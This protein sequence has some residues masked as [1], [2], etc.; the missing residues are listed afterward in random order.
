MKRVLG[1]RC[2]PFREHWCTSCFYW[3]QRPLLLSDTWYLC[4]D[5]IWKSPPVSFSHGLKHQLP[6]HLKAPCFHWAVCTKGKSIFWLKGLALRQML[7]GTLE[8]KEGDAGKVMLLG[9]SITT[10]QR[11]FFL[12]NKSGRLF[13]SGTEQ[14]SEYTGYAETY[15][16]ARSHEDRSERWVHFYFGITWPKAKECGLDPGTFCLPST[17]TWEI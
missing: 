11:H 4:M 17:L 7:P 8:D 6:S 3:R 16:W 13:V 15:R 5:S 1:N 10:L 12:K 14:Y 2:C 9:T